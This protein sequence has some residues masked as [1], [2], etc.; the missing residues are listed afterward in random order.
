VVDVPGVARSFFNLNER[1]MTRDTTILKTFRFQVTELCD[2]LED[3]LD[4]VQNPDEPDPFEPIH[5][6][7]DTIQDSSQRVECDELRTLTGQ[8]M[9]RV[10]NWSEGVSEPDTGELS[11]FR[12]IL[13]GIRSAMPNVNNDDPSVD[14]SDCRD[15]LTDG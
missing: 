8:M 3:L 2:D 9:E 11:A 10:T 6:T 15:L 4:Q 12:E 7:L 5:D 14:L 13:E 1:D